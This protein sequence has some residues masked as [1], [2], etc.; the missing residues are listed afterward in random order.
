M[1]DYYGVNNPS[2]IDYDTWKTTEPETKEDE[3]YIVENIKDITCPHCS[4]YLTKKEI[5]TDSVLY[6]MN[7]KVC[8]VCKHCDEG[9]FVNHIDECSWEV[10]KDGC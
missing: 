1:K 9:F 2:N 10:S 3:K 7:G 6:E 8:N 4:Y 5:R